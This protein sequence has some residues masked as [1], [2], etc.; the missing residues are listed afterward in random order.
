LE[1]WAE[2]HTTS[3][4][5]LVMEASGNAFA[6]AERLRGL[7]RKI[8]VL[9]SHQAGKV[10]KVYCANDRVD[11]VKIA[12]IYLQWF[13]RCGVATRRKD[14]GAARGL[15]RLPSGRQGEH[16]AQSSKSRRC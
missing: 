11:A 10:G 14:P 6:V 16:A 5:A 9:D 13:I 1:A 15:Q 8:V 3:E 4:D 7:G 12:R 2:R